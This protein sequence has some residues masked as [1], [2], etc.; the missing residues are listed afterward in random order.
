M[1]TTRT[2]RK[3]KTFYSHKETKKISNTSNIQ[4]YDDDGTFIIRLKNLVISDSQKD[5]PNFYAPDFRFFL[6]PVVWDGSGQAVQCEPQENLDTLADLGNIILSNNNSRELSDKNQVIFSADTA[7]GH[8]NILL[9]GIVFDKKAELDKKAIQELKTLVRKSNLNKLVKASAIEQEIDKGID[10][11]SLQLKKKITSIIEIYGLAN[12]R[13]NE[14][15][16]FFDVLELNNEKLNIQL[17]SEILI[18]RG[19]FKFATNNKTK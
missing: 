3:M 10:Q 18:N 13:S 6:L 2:I 14:L 12:Y 5:I 17:Q 16:H 4:H 1:V 7:E 11:L 8:L 9:L 15:I 19:G